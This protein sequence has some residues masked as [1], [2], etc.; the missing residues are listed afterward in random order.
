MKIAI[1]GANSSVGQNLLAH[2]ASAADIQAIA[3]V[4]SA[5]AFA[6]LPQSPRITPRVISYTDGDNLV[7]ALADADCV[8][9]LAGILIENK[10]TNYTSA[11][12]DATDAVAQA[13]FKAGVKHLVFISV[14]GASTSSANA[15]FRSKGLAEERVAA[16]GLSASIIRTPILLGSGTAGSDS[17]LAMAA[18]GK[19]KVLGG[20]HYTQRPLDVDDLSKAILSVCR[21]QPE[22][23]TIHELVGPESI[24]YRDLILRVASMQG[25]EVEIGSV[26]IA[27]AKLGAGI[28]SKLKGGG[29]TPTVID[30]I[31]MNEHVHSN[32]DT[33]L[34][35]LLTPL[36]STL[37]KIIRTI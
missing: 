5:A 37:E 23:V 10:H 31:T 28:T 7:T 1:T 30:V 33:A 35:I 21:A 27:I 18:K 3:G 26:P 8:I 36:Q 29:I 14:V 16:A 9:H 17:L 4:R 22:G 12:V 19:T 6:S 11:N 25:Q 32:A 15:Y 24:S 20:G 2:I 34:G 13:A